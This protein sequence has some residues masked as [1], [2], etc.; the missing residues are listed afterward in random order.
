MGVLESV[1]TEGSRDPAPVAG[2]SGKHS[3]G[4]LVCRRP[5]YPGA[6]QTART[7]HATIG[8]EMVA[9]LAA[10][11]DGSPPVRQPEP[12]IDRSD[13]PPSGIQQAPGTGLENPETGS[14]NRGY[15][16]LD[17]ID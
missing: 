14:Q 2:S 1:L 5:P 10:S 16:D 4:V 12:V 8:M 9:A 15:R 6:T 17:A 11:G 3:D 13:L 7:T